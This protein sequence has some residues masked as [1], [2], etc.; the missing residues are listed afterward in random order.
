LPDESAQRSSAARPD[1]SFR[2]SR[3]ARPDEST[4]A[5]A[6]RL[7]ESFRGSRE[8]PGETVCEHEIDEPDRRARAAALDAR[9]V[10]GA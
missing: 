6:A 4:S 1:E 8:A 7:D 10:R 5:R 2:G 3:E 9:P